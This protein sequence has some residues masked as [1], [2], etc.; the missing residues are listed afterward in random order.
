[1]SRILF[2]LPGFDVTGKI[3]LFILLTFDL[4][5]SFD[6]PIDVVLLIFFAPTSKIYV[7]Y[8]NNMCNVGVE[9]YDYC[10]GDR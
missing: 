7:I 9:I 4:T 1:M 5:G 6:D 10:M 2:L 8:Y 3:Q